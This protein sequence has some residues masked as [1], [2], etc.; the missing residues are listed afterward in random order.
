MGKEEKYD[1]L[2]VLE[3]TSNRKRMGV[4]VRCPDGKLKLYIKGAVSLIM[5]ILIFFY[6]IIIV[7]HFR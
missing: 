1:I 4:I 2:H 6:L 3:F 7:F 5:K